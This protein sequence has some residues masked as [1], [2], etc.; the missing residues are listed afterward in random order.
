[1]T[2]L[3]MALLLLLAAFVLRLG[4]LAFALYTLV[5]VAVLSR[6]LARIWIESIAVE[7]EIHR[8]QVEVGETVA[9]AVTLRNSGPWPVAWLLAE[10]VLPRR[11]LL[12]NPPDLRVVGRRLL[13]CYLRPQGTRRLLYQLKC[14]R[15]GYYQIGPTILETGDLFGLHRRCR[16][17]AAPHFITVL[18]AICPIQGYDIASRRP[19]GEVRLSYRLF[20]DPTRTTGVRPHQAG[21]PLNRIHWS[22]TARTGLL[23]SRVY[24][25]TCIAG[26]TLLIDF[27]QS[28]YPAQHEPVRSDLAVTAAASLSHALFEMGQQVGLISNGRDAADRVRREGWSVPAGT[29]ATIRQTVQMRETSDR[30][31]PL[32]IPAARGAPTHWQI[33]ELLARLELSD[34]LPLEHLILETAARMARDASVVAILSQVTTSHALA[35]GELAR[36]GLAVTAI[37]NTYEE[38]DFADRSG[39]LLAQGVATRHLQALPSIPSICQASFAGP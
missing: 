19:I 25:P 18:P 22:A 26:A 15:R 29:R 2:W 17:A 32:V 34:G 10:D 23:H 31:Q 36:R 38:V 35:L 16:V 1:M 37:I 3:A 33:L 8:T 9:V 7:R 12:F 13:L 28:S 6:Q 4:L 20:E 24:E 30:L 5:L 39:L 14:H 21:D 11:A 27:H